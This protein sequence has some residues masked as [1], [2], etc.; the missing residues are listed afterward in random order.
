VIGVEKA[1]IRKSAFICVISVI[2]VLDCGQ[3][4][5]CA[6]P[7]TWARASAAAGERRG[8]AE[9]STPRIITRPPIHIHDIS[10]LT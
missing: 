6:A 1:I 10:G 4:A 8:Q 7:G 3:A 2:C 9:I 5:G